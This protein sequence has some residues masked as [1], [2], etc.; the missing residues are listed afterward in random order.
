MA[1]IFNIVLAFSQCIPKFDGLV[2]RTGD[3]LPVIS[4]EADRQNIGSVANEAAS[5]QAGVEV[6]KTK[7]VV[8]GGGKGKLTVRRD[9]NVRNEVVMSMKNFLGESVAIIVTRQLPDDNCLVCCSG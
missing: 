7:C 9:D 4:A 6:P 5:S 2:T 1:I 8:P 3:D